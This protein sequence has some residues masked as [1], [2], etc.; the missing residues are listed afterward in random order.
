MSTFW[1][2][3]IS[4]I[5]LGTVFGC[6]WLLYA[7]R[8]NQTSDTET[9]RTMGHSFDGIEEYDNPLPKWWFY[10]FLATCIFALG[11]LALY[12]G[13]GN[14]K[15]L[16]GWSSTGQWETEM[17][18]ADAK[19]GELYAKFGD[20]PV[21]ELAGID[22]AMKM[23]QR[24]FANNCATCHGSA[25]RGSLGFPNLTDD[26]WLYGGDPDSILTTLHEGRNGN[27]PAMGTMPNMTNTQVDQVVNFVLSYSGRER[28]AEAAK[29]GEEVYAQACVACHGPD[30]TGNQALGAPNL[31]DN[32]W[33][34]GST[35][36]WIRETVVNGRQNNMP[37]QG[38][39]LSD[40]Q[41][42]I[43]AGYVY[44]LSN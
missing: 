23:G 11:Y 17:Q 5:V 18:Q 9:D 37:A 13:L 36:D 28:D 2:I 38:G 8:K 20:T 33:L 19:Y 4:V 16:L 27:M 22:D 24:L 15:G 12:P 7:T 32:T 30:G 41:I 40:D 31:T 1:S 35:Y 25:G 10:L 21:P 34:Y 3:W 42:Q 14:F 6:W 44:S 43:L 26:D 29:K 39:R